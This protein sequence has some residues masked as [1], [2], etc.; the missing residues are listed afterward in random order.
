MFVSTGPTPKIVTMVGSFE[1]LSVTMGKGFQ[2][3][4]TN[5]S[6]DHTDKEVMGE[7]G[8]A[9]VVCLVDSQRCPELRECLLKNE[10]KLG[11]KGT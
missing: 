10:G 5:I 2:S 11:G 1:C 8:C 6:R 4:P 9:G 7:S 3:P